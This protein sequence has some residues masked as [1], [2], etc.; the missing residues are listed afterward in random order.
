MSI[1]PYTRSDGGASVREKLGEINLGVMLLILVIAC[2]GFAMLYSAAC[3]S[4]Y[5]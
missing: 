3:G 2:V 5:P 1:S 4:L